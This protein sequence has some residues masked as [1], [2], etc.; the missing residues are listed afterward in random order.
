M[1]TILRINAV[2]KVVNADI[3]HIEHN[4]RPHIIVPSYT[5]PDNVV[6]NGGLYPAEE[7]KASFK[8][9]ENTL[10]PI[11]HPTI[12]GQFAGATEPEAINAHYVGV[13]NK[14]VKQVDGRV[15][16]EKWIDVEFAEK[17]EQG[18]QLL[19]AI[20]NGDEIHT[21]TGLLCK[22]E[23][24]V[25][26]AGYKWVA[27]S[28]QFDHDAILFDEPGAATPEDGVGMMVNKLE[29]VVNAFCPHLTTNGVLVD[30]FGQRRDALAASLKEMFGTTDN[31]VY[32]EDFDATTVVYNDS[33][34]LHSIGYEF[35]GGNAVLVGTATPMRAKV[36]FVAKGGAVGTEFALVKNAVQ[37]SLESEVKPINSPELE[38]MPLD[39]TALAALVTNAVNAAVSPLQAVVEAQATTIAALQSGLTANADATDNANRDLILAKNPGLKLAVNSL[40]GEALAEMAAQFQDAASLARGS[41]ETNAAKAGLDAFDQYEG[42]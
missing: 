35:E 30:S 14:N 39:E 40:K 9:L 10:A 24:A 13:W 6:M 12:N 15:Y 1:E 21:S 26:Q 11:G 37:C 2:A 17:F 19:E 28:M 20:E 22:R 27:R 38:P 16:I 32:V 34:G 41:M 8:S 7:I 23:V 36:E 33:T 4:G 31:Y 29:M 3:R 42:Q 25:N 5:L 18:R